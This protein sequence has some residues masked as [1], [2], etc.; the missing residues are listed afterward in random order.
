MDSW[1]K[2]LW[3]GFLWLFSYRW[4]LGSFQET[5]LHLSIM[6]W[7]WDSTV[8]VGL[9]AHPRTCNTFCICILHAPAPSLPF[10]LLMQCWTELLSIAHKNL[11]HV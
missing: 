4:L 3:L 5:L 11:C 2:P 1:T 6:G 8:E 9:F 7:V 10:L